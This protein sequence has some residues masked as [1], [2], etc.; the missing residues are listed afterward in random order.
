MAFLGLLLTG[1]TAA[2]VF[3]LLAAFQLY[4]G[5]GLLRL[6]ARS[7]VLTIYYSVFGAANGILVYALPGH[8]ARM[9]AMMKAM[10]AYFH[11]PMPTVMPFP[12]WLFEVMILVFML[13][14][15]YFLITRKPAFRA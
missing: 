9:A 14:Q 5:V 7:R 13:I 6:S 10:P 8:E 15:I 11:Q 2:S 3:V 4:I 1:W 12:Y